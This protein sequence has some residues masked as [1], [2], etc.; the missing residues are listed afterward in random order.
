MWLDILK[1][2]N[3]DAP[4][5]TDQPFVVVDASPLYSLVYDRDVSFFC[6]QFLKEG[7]GP[8]ATTKTR[9]LVVIVRRYGDG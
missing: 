8:N 1:D 7:N 5:T 3:S 2:T 4:T 6:I 9:V